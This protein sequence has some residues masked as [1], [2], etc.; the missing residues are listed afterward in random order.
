MPTAA[1]SKPARRAAASTSRPVSTTGAPKARTKPR[2]KAESKARPKA[3]VPVPRPR[4]VEDDMD[5]AMDTH[6][7]YDEALSGLLD[8]LCG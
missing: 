4:L 3:A 6:A 7:A 5:V 2:P 1:P 8:R